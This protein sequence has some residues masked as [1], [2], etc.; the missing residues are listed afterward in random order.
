[1][2]QLYMSKTHINVRMGVKSTYYLTANFFSEKTIST[3]NVALTNKNEQGAMDATFSVQKGHTETDCKR[4][5]TA[6][7]GCNRRQ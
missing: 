6:R 7:P 3:L 1:M 2:R 4:K 5:E